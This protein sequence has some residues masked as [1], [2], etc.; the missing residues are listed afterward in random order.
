MRINHNIAALNTYRQLTIGN[1]NAT[2][3]M[4]K[5]S[6]GLRINRAGDD[7]AGLAISEKMR[8][9]IRG[10]EQASRN[11]QDAISL[12]QTAE[13]ALNETHAIL[14]RMRELAVQASNGT[15]TES[16][17][18]QL[19]K[20]MDQLASE[21]SRISNTTE[22]NTKNL[23][24][25]GFNQNFHIGANE[26]QN[27]NLTLNAMDAKS[28]GLTEDV[29][30]PHAAVGIKNDAGV[31]GVDL[32]DGAALKEGT[33]TF[34]TEVRDDGTGAKVNLYLKD[35]AG[36]IVAKKEDF[37]NSSVSAGGTVTLTAVS[38]YP[39]AVDVTI[40]YGDTGFNIGSSMFAQ[41]ITEI[42]IGSTG[43]D[44]TNA[45]TNVKAMEVSS[46]KL[47]DGEY[48][49]DIIDD[50]NGNYIATVKDKDGNLLTDANGNVAKVDVSTQGD[51]TLTVKDK[52]G[53]QATLKFT[54]LADIT[55][56]E[57]A[58]FTFTNSEYK[59]GTSTAATANGETLSKEAFVA[60]GINISTIDAASKAITV[61]NKAIETVSTERSK[62]GAVQNRLEHTINNLGTAAENLTASESRI[63]DVDY[64]LAA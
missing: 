42:K 23:L 40:Q 57:S 22:F 56:A 38:G 12:I 36:N 41:T 17:R 37:D 54:T 52:S 29:A 3:N 55:A 62:L 64:A 2:K 6:S 21:I 9:Q 50:G 59:S 48:T 58:T 47:A 8:G 39:G 13:G 32:A 5:L 10:L 35:S 60:K 27:I 28:L 30:S 26:G 63:R 46:G 15:T 18:Q 14:Q 25:G 44:V 33:Y 11:A 49:L 31:K 53:N 61:I 20:E 4:E 1:A 24:G 19:Q 45:S 51:F 16:D 7:A 34:V 43:V